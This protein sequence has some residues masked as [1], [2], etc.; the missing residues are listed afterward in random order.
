[1]KV[2]TV[3]R[4]NLL[5]LTYFSIVQAAVA[6]EKVKKCTLSGGKLCVNQ[7]RL[8]LVKFGHIAS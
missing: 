5:N 6:L 3:N 8:A 7:W 1:M 2:G 4:V